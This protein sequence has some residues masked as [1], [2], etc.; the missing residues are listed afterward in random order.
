MAD[1][2]AAAGVC[3]LE[4]LPV[5]GRFALHCYQ[6]AAVLAQPAS[7]M[8]AEYAYVCACYFEDTSMPICTAWPCYVASQ[9]A[10]Y[11]LPGKVCSELLC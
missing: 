5:S 6:L 11:A 4:S 10:S 2:P 9:A 8:R 1:T 7:R 3:S